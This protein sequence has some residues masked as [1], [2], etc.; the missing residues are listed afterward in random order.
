MARFT[1]SDCM[2]NIEN[3]FDM[4]V[5]AAMRAR[6]I[7]KGSELLVEQDEGDKATIIALREIAE[8]KVTADILNTVEL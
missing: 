5:A 7:E 4:T 3:R 8:Q 2:E 6:Q 1:V